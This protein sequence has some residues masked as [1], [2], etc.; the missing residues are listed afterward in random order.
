MKFSQFVGI[1]T[2]NESPFDSTTFTDVDTQANPSFK[3]T[4][5]DDG[6][7]Q[8]LVVPENAGIFYKN[9]MRGWASTLQI[10]SAEIRSGN[11]GFKSKEVSLTFTIFGLS[12]LFQLD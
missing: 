6:L 8:E 1:H 12:H 3:I 2:P 10:N 4:L 11:R 9:L 5:G 7:F